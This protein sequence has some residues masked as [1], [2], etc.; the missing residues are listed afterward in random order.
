MPGGDL[1]VHLAYADTIGPVEQAAAIARKAEAVQPHH[2]DVTR[3]IRL[4]LFEDLASLV[5]RREQQPAQDLLIAERA[6]WNAQA[7]RGLPDDRSDLRIGTRRTVALLVAIP[8]GA[9]LLPVPA[10]LHEAIGDRLAAEVRV[11]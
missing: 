1:V 9:R 4:P 5:H 10:H 3:P 7:G 8:A 2:V 11:L 6:L